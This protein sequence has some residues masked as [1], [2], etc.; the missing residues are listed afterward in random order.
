MQPIAIVYTSNTGHT[1][2]YA[3][4]LG[5]KTGLMVYSMAEAAKKLEKGTP[6]YYL[7]WLFASRVKGYKKAAKKYKLCA[8]C[9]VGLCDTGTLL[10]EGRR[11]I[12]LSDSIPFFTLQGGMELD[13]LKGFHK[14]MIRMLTKGLLSKSDRTPDEERMLSLLQKGGNYVNAANLSAVLDHFHHVKE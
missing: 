7:G 8:V 12:A 14:F 5:E 13:K 2:E 10:D 1:A 4:L 11:A 9:G 3:K 6:V